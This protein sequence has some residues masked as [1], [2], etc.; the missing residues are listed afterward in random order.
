MTL[1]L[2]RQITWFIIG[3]KKHIIIMG[4]LYIIT[5]VWGPD[6]YIF[7]LEEMRAGNLIITSLFFWNVEMFN[8]CAWRCGQIVLHDM[9]DYCKVCFNRLFIIWTDEWCVCVR[10]KGVPTVNFCWINIGLMLVPT[11]D[12]GYVLVGS[13]NFFYC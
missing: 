13:V 5:P 7:V 12:T 2:S 10:G 1:S 9:H 3:V 8:V 11:L 4:G 6:M